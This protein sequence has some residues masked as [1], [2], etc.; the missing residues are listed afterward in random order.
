MTNNPSKDSFVTVAKRNKSSRPA[1]GILPPNTR[2]RVQNTTQQK[3]SIPTQIN[4]NATSIEDSSHITTKSMSSSQYKE[5]LRQQEE[6]LRQ[7][8]HFA[9][10]N[11]RLLEKVTALQAREQDLKSTINGLEF[12]LETSNITNNR[13]HKEIDHL[14]N[15]V[16][17]LSA[18]NAHQDSLK[19]AHQGNVVT[20]N[21]KNKNKNKNKNNLSSNDD[22]DN[23]EFEHG[24]PDDENRSYPSVSRKNYSTPG[25]N[26]N[27]TTATGQN[28]STIPVTTPPPQGAPPA[29]HI[30]TQYRHSDGSILWQ[31]VPTPVPPPTGNSS[32][33]GNSS[34]AQTNLNH[35][36]NFHQQ[37]QFTAPPGCL[38]F[39]R[40]T[41]SKE[42]KDISCNSDD[43]NDIKTWFD[44]L[45]S[46]LL[47]A[48][49]GKEVLPKIENLTP[50]HNFKLTLLPPPHQTNFTIAKNA[51][52]ALSSAVRLYLTKK[53]TFEDCP[54][55]I[56]ALDLH[57]SEECG[58][59]MLLKLLCDIF[60]HLGAGY[61]DFVNEVN[62]LSLSHNDSVYSLLRK[63]TSLQR[64]LTHTNQTHPPNSIIHKFLS[65]LR[66]NKDMALQLSSIYLAYNTHLKNHGPNIAFPMTPHEIYKHLK[67]LG[68]DPKQSLAIDN[69]I[70]TDSSSASE[71]EGLFHNPVARA[72]YVKVEEKPLY[73]D[74][75]FTKNVTRAN[76]RYKR[77][78][79]CNDY[80]PSG[81]NPELRCPARGVQWI[82]DWKRKAAAKYNAMHPKESPDPDFINA[83][84]PVR[85][86]TT[87]PTAKQ[88]TI[89]IDDSDNPSDDIFH[90]AQEEQFQENNSDDDYTSA[91]ED[92]NIG[93][94]RRP[95]SKMARA[96]NN[97]IQ[98]CSADSDGLYRY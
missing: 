15:K 46:C 70:K 41:W 68:V 4:A 16:Y 92:E 31:I 76:S 82:P 28:N 21:K 93:T 14:G 12:N 72:A 48:T 95:V 74:K 71:N 50:N 62:K 73:P 37:V 81:A 42:I 5:T 64:R 23:S 32:S 58:L 59:V 17:E 38:Q 54:D 8:E 1:S 9:A 94:D 51:F 33:S 25:T 6:K 22:D 43:L 98:S 52:N 29:G 53:K 66:Q 13:L 10:E 20:E 80:H 78:E 90:D 75:K 87:K 2:S 63:T 69:R 91:S 86:G 36:P 56:L 89:P 88:V 85:S 39:H 18:E 26:N 60:P 30:Y 45:S 7:Q 47:S 79:I 55:T 44:D 84:P 97:E 83:P 57:K 11:K 3:A 34:S 40:P 96:S 65:E 35:N 27:I 19:E 61:V 24:D 49:Q 77:C 67:L